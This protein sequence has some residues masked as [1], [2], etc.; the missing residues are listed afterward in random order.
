M[1]ND[2]K[3]PQ[4]GKTI[5][6]PETLVARLR[7]MRDRTAGPELGGISDLLDEAAETIKPAIKRDEFIDEFVKDLTGCQSTYISVHHHDQTTWTAAELG[8][9]AHDVLTEMLSRD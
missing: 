9:L 2:A 4:L 8:S 7:E 3:T 1:S 6:N 5:R